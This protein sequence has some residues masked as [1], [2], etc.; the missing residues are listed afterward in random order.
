M[1]DDEQDVYVAQLHEVFDSC[2]RTGKGFLDRAELVELCKKLQLDDQIPQLLQQLLGNEESNGQVSFED[3]KEGF[4]AVLSLAIDNL[5]SS[6]DEADST[7]DNAEPPKLVVNEKRYGRK[8]KPD[9]S[10]SEDLYSADDES[11]SE[12]RT[13]NQTSMK[14]TNGVSEKHEEE[15]HQK[16]RGKVKR[17]L[18]SRKSS[19]R[20]SIRRHNSMKWQKRTLSQDETEVL[21]ASGEMKPSQSP[22]P[23]N[24]G[25]ASP[26]EP[27]EEDQLKAIWNEVH[28]GA[29]GF[30]DRHELALVCDHIG[31]DS[32]NEQEL[33]LLFQ[34]LDE[35]D[36]GKV[37]FDEFLNGLFAAKDHYQDSIIEE[38]VMDVQQSTPYSKPH[39]NGLASS[40]RL[41]NTSSRF[42]DLF[43]SRT[44][45]SSSFDLLSVLDPDNTGFAKIED[46]KDVWA[47]Q[48]LDDAIELLEDYPMH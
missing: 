45:A 41:K 9:T 37:S 48:G 25:Y 46:I 38:E 5:S 15:T 44:S 47:A 14:L 20:N 17:R 10:Y 32:M 4:V 27:S 40:G 8:S 11:L 7:L 6:E 3:F 34:E 24:S 18:S 19:L 42:D 23:A 29:T 35:D 26:T 30:L 36:D 2:D 21:E 28:V 13:D 1:D 33:T 22:I 43:L 16:E 12:S 31:M 39:V